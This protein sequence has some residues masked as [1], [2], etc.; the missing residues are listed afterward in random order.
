MSAGQ[1]YQVLLEVVN[2]GRQLLISELQ[3]EANELCTCE[4]ASQGVRG[5]RI[6]RIQKFILSVEN[7]KMMY[8]SLSKLCAQ[9]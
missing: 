6:A 3:I 7:G 4:F 1:F 2:C 9:F 5:L 8:Q